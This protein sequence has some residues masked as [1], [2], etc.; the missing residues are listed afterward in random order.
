MVVQYKHLYYRTPAVC[1]ALDWIDAAS[2]S[3]RS[4][5]FRNQVR[6]YQSGRLGTLWHARESQNAET[7]DLSQRS[8]AEEKDGEAGMLH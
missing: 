6:R 3:D 4:H 1:D 2:G 8:Q 5:R 7:Q